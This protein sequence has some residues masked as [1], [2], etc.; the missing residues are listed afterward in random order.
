M[1]GAL[2]RI[3]I[4]GYITSSLLCLHLRVVRVTSQ[5]MAT[6]Y[7]KRP[8]VQKNIPIPFT[9]TLTRSLAPTL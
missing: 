6:A 4:L 2:L 8:S 3:F 1:I 7:M 5:N 9:V